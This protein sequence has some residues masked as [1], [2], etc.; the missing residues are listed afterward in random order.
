MTNPRILLLAGY[1]PRAQ[2]YA[3]AL[4]SA[5]IEPALVLMY[6]DPENDIARKIHVPTSLQFESVN[7]PDLSKTLAETCSKHGW[8]TARIPATSVNDSSV[9]EAIDSFRPDLVIYAGYGGQIVGSEML[10]LGYPVLHCHPGW[11]PEFRGSTTIYYSLLKEASCAVSAIILNQG[12]DTGPVVLRQRYPAPI[13]IDVDYVYDNAI[14]ADTMIKVVTDFITN[15]SLPVGQ[16]QSAS[17]T[18]YYIIHPL[19]K[20]A[21]LLMPPGDISATVSPQTK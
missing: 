18:T 19:L 6:G 12:I 3:Q 17:G 1:T 8:D 2:A 21:A 9:S 20:H 15:K 10:D 7:L 13:Q 11:L 5:Q 16:Q 14:R 4:A